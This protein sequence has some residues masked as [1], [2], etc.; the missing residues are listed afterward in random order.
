MVEP[1]DEQPQ[2]A[3]QASERKKRIHFPGIIGAVI[4]TE[5]V[6]VLHAANGPGLDRQLTSRSPIAN[7]VFVKG[8]ATDITIQG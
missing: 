6:A 1:S 4:I 3:W 7:T 5:P 2:P 8:L